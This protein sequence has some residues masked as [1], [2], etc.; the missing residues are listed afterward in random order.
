MLS[1]RSLLLLLITISSLACFAA[2]AATP[3]ENEFLVPVS[4]YKK[5][6]RQ[7]SRLEILA[8]RKN[9]ALKDLRRAEKEAAKYRVGS[10]T[11]NL[12][13]RA[14]ETPFPTCDTTG[15]N[16]IPFTGFTQI[17]GWYINRVAPY[18]VVSGQSAKISS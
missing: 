16:A 4:T 8:R 5:T 7:T 14:S 10:R 3:L 2:A 11:Q 12:A 13:P 17:P 6:I 15:N 9:K 18:D 1:S